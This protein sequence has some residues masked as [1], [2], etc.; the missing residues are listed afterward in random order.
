[1]TDLTIFAY[2]SSAVRTISREGEPWFVATDIAKIL[3]YKLATDMA[4]MLDED[5]KGMQ[6][7][8]TL[9]G[10]Q[11]LLVVSE[12]G[13]YAA[14]LKSRRPE[15]KKFRKWVTAEVLPSIRKTGAYLDP[16]AAVSPAPTFLTGNPSHGADLVVAAD[17]TFRSFM[18]AARSSG[19]RL[20]QA[21]AVAN[22][23]TL[24]RTGMDMLA[25]LGVVPEDAEPGDAVAE[26]G[27]VA[28]ADDW[29]QGRLPLPAVICRSADLFAAYLVW[30]RVQ[31]ERL[32]CPINQFAGR[33]CAARR[34]VGKRHLNALLGRR[35]CRVRCFIVGN[36]PRQA[37]S[38]A[39]EIERF[40]VALADWTAAPG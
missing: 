26:G 34:E 29:L 21:L 31:G 17:R 33:L 3:G 27:V 18:R 8:H 36:S 40:S 2:E 1:M 25:E 16:S 38:V 30:C 7:L 37:A 13:L 11:E 14:I 4:K 23:Q 5:E 9:G 39:R 19:L 22:R 15:A 12:S 20:P 10:D 32:P 24:A 28:F 35:L 6:N